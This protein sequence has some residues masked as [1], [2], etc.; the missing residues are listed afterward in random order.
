M[1]CR[2]GKDR[3]ARNKKNL[4]LLA[5]VSFLLLSC[6]TKSV[7]EQDTKIQN[8]I[9][10]WGYS[11]EKLNYSIYQKTL[12]YPDSKDEFL[13]EYR[14]YYYSGLTVVSIENAEPKLLGG[15]RYDAVSVSVGAM[16]VHRDKSAPEGQMHG[17]IE[18]VRPA[19]SD[20]DWKIH[21]KILMRN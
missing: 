16:T 14:D 21:S 17:T 15:E 10:K 9:I 18:L 3:T 8:V 19:G 13:E 2:Y 4:I 12:K 1:K 6:S 20:L 11:I 5:A 7:R